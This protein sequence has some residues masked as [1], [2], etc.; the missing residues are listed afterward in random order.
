MKK[1]VKPLEELLD[2]VRDIDGFPIG[3]DED[4]LALSNPPYYTACP[5][6]YLND[7]VEEYGVFYDEKTD[8]YHREPFTGDVSEGKNDPV[9]NAHPYHTKVPYK[10]IVKYIKHYTQEGDI[11]LD[12]FCGTG[13]TGV[14]AQ[15]L[16]RKVIL[17]DLSPIASLISSNY[18]NPP[19]TDS[20]EKVAH[21]ILHEA[22][23]ECLWMYQTI[24]TEGAVSGNYKSTGEYGI[25]NFVIWS[26]IFNCPY[27]KEEYVFYDH[28]F[29]S[30][31]RKV[32]KEYHC[33]KCKALINKKESTHSTEVIFDRILGEEITSIKQT[34]V[35][36]NYT[37][38]KK[39][40]NKSPDSNDFSLIEKIS[41]L[42]T[43][44]WHPT[45][46]MPFGSET[47]RNDKVGITH[48][49]HFYTQQNIHTLGVLWGKIAQV[50]EPQLKLSLSLIHT[51]IN[52]YASKMR[53]FRPDGKG[54]GPLP[55]TLYVSSLMTPPNVLLSFSRNIKFMSKA[56][57]CLE[58]SNNNAIVG[59][60]S[61]TNIPVQND[62]ID[63]IFTDPPFGDNLMYSEL[64]Y[65]WEAWFKVTTNCIS[66]AIISKN[67][68]KDLSEYQTLM[69]RSFKEYY[70]ILKPNR[71][72]TVVF[73]NSKSSIWN[74]IQDSLMKA[75]FIVSQ[76]SIMDKK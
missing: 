56:L 20:F 14:A 67:Q 66:E 50:S 23:N 75:G 55:G 18:N 34:P 46:R 32:L 70:R 19:D 15:T 51:A 59:V 40:F 65:L 43:P 73:H 72:I 24:H 27:C 44:Y 41:K 22:T 6:P 58:L 26:D 25:I 45:E 8:D 4:I 57:V 30:D 52:N 12:G 48:V 61:A 49:H 69:T 42:D 31:T 54:G 33:P 68:N 38:N 29:D 2:S 37:Y 9:Y 64:N 47:R 5:N 28:A 21:K 13:M 10:A 53:R 3:T 62:S 60:N 71:W 39:R 7:F 76:V 63:Y 74:V 36:I 16:N 35:L 11:V 17:A 1:P